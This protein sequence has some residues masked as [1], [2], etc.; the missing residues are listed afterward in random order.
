MDILE[1]IVAQQQQDLARR[2][3]L[4]PSSYLE[5]SPLFS[6]ETISLK[7]S[8]YNS[9]T[10]IIAEFK[11]RSPSKQVINQK[12]QVAAVTQDY[13]QAG[14]SGISVLTNGPFFGGS[15]EDL[16]QARA[17]V[18][19]PLLRKE[20]IIDEYQI[21]EAK[22]HGADAILLIAACL[23]RNQI[24]QLA[25]VAKNIGLEVLLEVHNKE[26]LIK[27]IMP[28]LDIIGVNN[29]NLKTFAVNLNTSKE[30]I[31]DIPKEF[32]PISESGIS[33]VAAVKELQA[34][35]FQGFLMGE[36][37]MKTSNPGQSAT[38]FINELKA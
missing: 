15:L 31:Q 37:F 1:R 29:R 12:V 11:R 30:L 18:T 6:R 24:K 22:A 33:S 14:V 5:A 35:G 38:D 21:L 17:S 13:E 8:L 25:K 2:K 20:F 7:E 36:N 27:T 16:N 19:I 3:S 26:E 4:F 9:Q 32:V 34:V 28:E 10:G 23:N